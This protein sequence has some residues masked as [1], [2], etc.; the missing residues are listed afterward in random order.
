MALCLLRIRRKKGSVAN[1]LEAV[2]GCKWRQDRA[3]APHHGGAHSLARS[4]VAE[5]ET[6]RIGCSGWNYAAWR[7]TFYP[8]GLP[9]RMARVLRSH[10]DTVELNNS[11][12]RLPERETFASWERR[13]PGDF[14]FAVK[15]SR[16]LTH[17]KRLRDPGRADR[18]PAVARGRARPTSGPDPL[19]APGQH[20]A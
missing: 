10:F 7:G 14:L 16:F 6:P 4:A 2:S 17:M 1:G 8:V 3:C 11:F 9:P 13:V 5:M 15:A 19:P 20:D 18:A 12:Y